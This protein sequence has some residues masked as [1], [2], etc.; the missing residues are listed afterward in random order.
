MYHRSGGSSPLPDHEARRKTQKSTAA[1]RQH[2][3]ASRP[4]L[5]FLFGFSAD[6]GHSW[7]TSAR[8]NREEVSR[9]SLPSAESE[10]HFNIRP[11]PADRRGR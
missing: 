3:N 2:T 1:M 6:C 4:G 10:Q 5:R 8:W 11:A 7:K 9:V